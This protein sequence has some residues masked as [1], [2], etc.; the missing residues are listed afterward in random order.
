VQLAVLLV[1]SAYLQ[2][3]NDARFR[4]VLVTAFLE[5]AWDPSRFRWAEGWTGKVEVR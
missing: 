1:G 2:G 5:D 4:L 3:K